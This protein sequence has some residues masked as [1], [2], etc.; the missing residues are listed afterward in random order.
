V[1]NEE[2]ARQ[3]FAG[4]EPLGKRLR[5]RYIDQPKPTEPWLT[6]VGIVGSTRSIRY[7][8]IQWD[9]YPAVYTSFFQGANASSPEAFDAQI[10]FLYRTFSIR[11]VCGGLGGS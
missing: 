6:I 10:L 3:Y 11:R 4:Q 7:N 8:H 9:K 2:M 5:F 1:I